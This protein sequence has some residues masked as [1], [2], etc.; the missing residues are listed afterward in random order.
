MNNPI[1]NNR[2]VSDKTFA[3][4]FRSFIKDIEVSDA[5]SEEEKEYLLQVANDLLS[6]QIVTVEEESEKQYLD[7]IKDLI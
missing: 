3:I 1:K 2:I 7:N 6:Y 5:I 4:R